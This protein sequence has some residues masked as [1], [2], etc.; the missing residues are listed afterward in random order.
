MARTRPAEVIEALAR[1]EV[2]MPL[3]TVG[4]ALT[5]AEGLLRAIE[6]TQWTILEAAGRLADARA[7]AAKAIRARVAEALCKDELALAL[8]PALRSAQDEAARLLADVPKPK[9][10][11]EPPPPPPPPQGWRL[12]DAEA[13]KTLD[14]EEGRRALG[15]IEKEL[16]PGRRL[17]ISWRIEEKER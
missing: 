11:P 6:E 14:D 9:P 8:A 12:V 2:P 17:T 5:R 1:V 7:E 16:K 15:R 4:H 3:Q 10:G 13:G